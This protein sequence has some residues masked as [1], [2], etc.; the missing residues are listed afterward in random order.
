M[1]VLL[2]KV[3][4]DLHTP[5]NRHT[6]NTKP[7]IILCVHSALSGLFFFSFFNRNT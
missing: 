2:N 1:I 4:P 5:I 7:N 6:K 3:S